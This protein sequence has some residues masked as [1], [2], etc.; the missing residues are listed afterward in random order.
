MKNS[1]PRLMNLTF[2]FLL[3]PFF[4][5]S[6]PEN[7]APCAPP[8]WDVFTM[9]VGYEEGSCSVNPNKLT[10]VYPDNSCEKDRI[11]EITWTLP[12]DSEIV[13][14]ELFLDIS[15]NGDYSV[16][17]TYDEGSAESSISVQESVNVSLEN[18]EICEGET[19]TFDA[20]PQNSDI[21][22]LSYTWLNS[23]SDIVGTEN[24]FET[25]EAGDYSVII[26]TNTPCVYNEDISL[27]VNATP[28]F[29]LFESL[30]L[31]DDPCAKPTI[32]IKFDENESNVFSEYVWT[33][34]DESIVKTIEPMLYASEEGKYSLSVVSE[35]GC[36]GSADINISFMNTPVSDIGSCDILELPSNSYVILANA[37]Q[38]GNGGSFFYSWSKD[39][40]TVPLEDDS[41]LTIEVDGAYQIHVDWIYMG[42]SNSC[43]YYSTS[44]VVNVSFSSEEESLIEELEISIREN[45]TQ[46][47]RVNSVYD[48]YLWSTGET[49]QQ[50]E[51]KAD[52]YGVGEY[53]IWVEVSDDAS[54]YGKQVE[55]SCSSKVVIRDDVKLTISE[56]L[57]LRA[58]LS[59][60]EIK[61][62][63]I[64][65]KDI[66]NIDLPHSGNEIVNLE[67]VSSSGIVVLRK[68]YKNKSKI[69]LDLRTIST[70]VYTVI[71]NYGDKI[72]RERIIKE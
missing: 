30:P 5:W 55:G 64:P 69:K 66:L 15:E 23:A 25:G 41:K 34:P 62:S 50:I 59:S 68:N 26:T 67:L 42:D 49:T 14:T 21:T 61:I 71:I 12:D 27:I 52:S 54:S 36:V 46:S 33:L 20:T 3:L 19:F 32:E 65:T 16:F 8:I 24:R 40:E 22:V 51:I 11:S 63:P 58:S 29:E 56:A 35:Y 38:S 28:K 1:T 18:A 7:G 53:E 37:V 47:L 17:V 6:Q 4:S 31:C 57:G 48:S 70:G 39:G 9:E 43:G 44:D 10:L 60:K 45:E 2:L 72:F 13:T